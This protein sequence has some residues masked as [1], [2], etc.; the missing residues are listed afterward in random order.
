MV[1]IVF[2]LNVH[3]DCSYSGVNYCQVVNPVLCYY[4]TMLAL[5]VVLV[6]NLKRSLNHCEGYVAVYLFNDF[7]RGC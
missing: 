7:V 6:V 3:V 1:L 5:L 4:N 2:E